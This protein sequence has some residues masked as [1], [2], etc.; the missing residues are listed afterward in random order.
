MRRVNLILF[1]TELV[2]P[3]L[4]FVHFLPFVHSALLDPG[5]ESIHRFREPFEVFVVLQSAEGGVSRPRV[6]HLE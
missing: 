2:P 4:L 1:K 3:F 5:D 6:G